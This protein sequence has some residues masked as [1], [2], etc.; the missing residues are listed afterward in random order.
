MANSQ[1]YEGRRRQLIASLQENSAAIV[2]S[3]AIRYRN[4]D[5]EYPFRQHS[6]FYYLTGFNEPDALLLITTRNNQPKTIL[7]N[8]PN[9]PAQECWTGPRLG[10]E[11]A[12]EILGVDEAY[13]INLLDQ[14]MTEIL[15]DLNHIY[16]PFT[17]SDIWDARIM[18]WLQVL[19]RQ[20]RQGV[21]MPASI[22]DLAPACHDLRLRKSAEEIERMR[23]AAKVTVD[24]H[25]RAMQ[26][27][28]AGCYEYE[29][30]AELTHEFTRQGCRSHA[31]T[32]IVAAGNNSCVLHYV[33]NNSQVNA[34]DLIL[35][36]AGAEYQ[37][38]A[39]DVTRTFPV[40]GTFTA[41]QQAIYE[42]V[43]AAQ[44][45]VIEQVK[46]G[47]PWPYLQETAAKIITQGLV[48][49]GLLSGEVNELIEQ[50]AYTKFY[51]HTSGH[52]LG[53]DVHDVGGYKV[54]D[55]WRQ[56]EP[57]MALT[58]EPGIYIPEGTE[59]VDEDWWKIGV[60]IEDD[61]VVTEKGCDVLSADLP[62]TVADIEALMSGK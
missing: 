52:W 21:T 11:N 42:I 18:R 37:N 44:L 32:P 51:M 43:C 35:I 2:P 50:R 15:A 57:N 60:R 3:A 20:V 40:D 6:D 34:G 22:H 7:F 9:D 5:A 4:A 59:G 58:V 33:D 56:L 23:M 48:D 1:E 45:A 27:A 49:V 46:P 17:Q 26:I 24:G 16:Y 29:L 55:E 39:A 36:D 30:E 13:D 61:V 14:Q 10:Q 47:T 25:R 62:K 38:Y 12:G 54:D 53:L 31:Y 19:Q 41:K 8:R 28:K